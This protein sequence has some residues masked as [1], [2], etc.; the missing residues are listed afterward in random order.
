MNGIEQLKQASRKSQE[1]VESFLGK[2][3]DEP[4]VIQARTEEL[5]ALPT[6]ELVALILTLEKPKVERAF[7][8]E[9]IVKVILEEP[10]C[11]LFNYEQVATIVHQILPDA[12]TSHKSVASYASKKKGEW[13]I[14]SRQKFS[15]SHEDLLAIGQ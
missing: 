9:D 13:D 3:S 12:K 10:D 4:D 1:I 8:V 15:L 7:K 2:L 11:A 5:E 14:V 6:E